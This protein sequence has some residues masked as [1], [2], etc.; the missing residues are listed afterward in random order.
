MELVKLEMT[1]KIPCAFGI[2]INP[3]LEYINA[4]NSTTAYVDNSTI[5]YVV[6]LEERGKKRWN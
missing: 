6:L 2:P 4:T 1:P 3:Q 5:F